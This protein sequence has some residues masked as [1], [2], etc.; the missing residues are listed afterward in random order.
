MTVVVGVQTSDGLVLASDSATTQRLR[1]D[2]DRRVTSS[3]WNSAN[4]IFNLRKTWPIGAMTFGRASLSG[5]TISTHAKD[6]RRQFEGPESSTTSAG[7]LGAD[8]YTL[9]EVTASTYNFF[10]ELYDKEPGGHLG[11]LVGGFSATEVSPEL[12]QVQIREDKNNDQIECVLERGEAGIAH[13]GITDAITRLMDG[14]SQEMGGAF[15]DLG[16]PEGQGDELAEMLRGQL[17]VQWA[18]PA[19]PLG[20]TIDLARF[21]V[22]TQIN[23]TRFVPG[24]ATVGGPIEIAALTRHEGFKWVQRKQYYRSDLNPPE[25]VTV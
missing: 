22:D 20:E 3:I 18:W 21:L 4:K 13:Q 1:Q 17:K 14:A 2:D 6:L 8:A 10:R 25:D 11:F 15:E 12:W 5:L 9:E 23:F 19:M 7:R 16:I 24:D